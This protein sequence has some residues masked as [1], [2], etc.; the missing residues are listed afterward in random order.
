MK[1]AQFFNRFG[2]VYEIIKADWVRDVTECSRSC[3]V[4]AHLYQ[5]S[6]VECQLV[7]EAMMRLAPKFKYVKFVK[8]RSTQA[9]ENWPEKNLP[10][11]FFYH[12]GELK[13]QLITLSAVGGKKM[14]ADGKYFV[15][16]LEF[17]TLNALPL[18]FDFKAFSLTG[19]NFVF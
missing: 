7:E 2:E 4:A 16:L 15:A 17:N 13:T 12:S 11:V 19:V 8:I 6:V 9:I 14:T 3:W 18:L 1:I 10:T 5:D